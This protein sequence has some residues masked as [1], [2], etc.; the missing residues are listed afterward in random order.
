ML[1]PSVNAQSLGAMGYFVTGKK[2][3]AVNATVSQV[4]KMQN[5][6]E[7]ALL[8]KATA[9]NFGSKFLIVQVSQD[10]SVFI[11]VDNITLGTATIKGVNYSAANTATTVPVNPALFPYVKVYT[12]ALVTNGAQTLYW[13]GSR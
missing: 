9:G 4:I 11:T 13:S 5:A 8:L 1:M 7:L 2:V 12:S 6:K 3:G 10:N